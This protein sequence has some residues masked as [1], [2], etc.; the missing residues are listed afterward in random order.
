MYSFS[1][2]RKKVFAARSLMSGPLDS[3]L[4]DD[5]AYLTRLW[6]S[7]RAEFEVHA[8]EIACANDATVH[9]HVRVLRIM[10]DVDVAQF[11]QNLPLHSVLEGKMVEV[12]RVDFGHNLLGVE[13]RPEHVHVDRSRILRGVAGNRTTV[14]IHVDVTILD[15]FLEVLAEQPPKLRPS[16]TDAPIVD[17]ART[18][19]VVEH[20]IR[21]QHADAARLAHSRNGVR[22]EPLNA[23]QARLERE[24][25]S[26]DG[27]HR[28]RRSGGDENEKGHGFTLWELSLWSNRDGRPV[29]RVQG[30]INNAITRAPTYIQLFF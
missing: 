4:A 22:L 20:L 12:L 17:R 28:G 11:L 26:D 29:S 16:H 23:Q 18:D 25:R 1:S 2:C 9:D 6:L 13:L 24:E 14:V 7:T 8:V 19:E 27:R 5:S 30:T 15:G 21:Q 10:G 3:R